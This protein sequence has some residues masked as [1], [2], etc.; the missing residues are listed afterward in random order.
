MDSSRHATHPVLAWNRHVMTRMQKLVYSTSAALRCMPARNRTSTRA[1]DATPAN[2]F[3][4]RAI[5][6]HGTA[7]R[8]FTENSRPAAAPGSRPSFPRV[9]AVL[10]RPARRAPYLGHTRRA[11]DEEPSSS[12][13]P[14]ADLSR[15]NTLVRHLLP[16]SLRRTAAEDSS[17]TLESSPTMASQGCSV[18]AGL[19]Q[20]PEDPILGV[21]HS[22]SLASPSPLPLPSLPSPAISLPTDF[23]VPP[24]FDR[25]G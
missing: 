10:A 15:L 14:S 18:F 4:A 6:R 12:S 7:T 2:D 3:S 23:P 11:H 19:A 1:R 8:D 5:R 25:S 9:P 13:S 22:L 20:A 16:S 24:S 21:S 17:A